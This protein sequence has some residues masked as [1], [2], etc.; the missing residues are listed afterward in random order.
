MAPPTHCGPDAVPDADAWDLPDHLT[1][2]ECL[3][4]T[5]FP[6]RRADRIPDPEEDL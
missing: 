1:W 2:E 5:A 4:E 6:A 3:E